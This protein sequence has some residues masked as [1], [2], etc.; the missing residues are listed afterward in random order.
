MLTLE[1]IR[2]RCDEVGDCWIWTQSCAGNSKTPQMRFERRAVN[3]RRVTFF[4]H[5]GFWP[6][7][8]C[9]SCRN[10]KCVAPGCAVQTTA[11]GRGRLARKRP[12]SAGRRAAMVARASSRFTDEMIATVRAASNAKEGAKAVGMSWAYAKAIRSGRARKDYSNPFAG[13]GA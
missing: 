11:K 9:A 8:V 2:M 6:S 5:N 12:E 4:L 1:Q 13:L 7:M 10:P 3:A